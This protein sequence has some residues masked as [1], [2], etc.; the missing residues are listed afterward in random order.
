[1]KMTTED[2][3]C[4]ICGEKLPT[5]HGL[6]KYCSRKCSRRRYL[7]K[8]QC[9]VCNKEYSPFTSFSKTCSQK[10]AGI[11][12]QKR[13]TIKCPTCKK[14]IIRTNWEIKIGRIY[15]SKSCGGKR[16]PHKREVYSKSALDSLWAKL[17]KLRAGNKCEICNKTEKLVSHHFIGRRNYS[18]R[19]NLNNGVCLCNYHHYL[20]NCSA[21]QNPVW[22]IFEM[23]QKRGEKWLNELMKESKK[24]YH[25]K[26]EA[27]FIR[28]Y[29]YKEDLKWYNN[30]EKKK[31]E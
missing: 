4:I 7:H 6:R 18:V 30:L 14:Q 12:R 9:I 2:K 20:S 22:F 11:L 21:H 19:W 26:K 24:V 28:E 10:C 5:S 17:I 29:L 8:K 23:K 25:W 3:K 1:M 27:V 15:C 31:N 13:Q 16:K